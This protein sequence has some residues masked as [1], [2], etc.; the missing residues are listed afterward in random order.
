[1]TEAKW[2][3]SPKRFEAGVPNMAQAVGFAAAINYLNEVGM[4]NVAKHEQDLTSY[5]L[6]KFLQLDKVEVI[7]PKNNI[8]RGS[9]I[10]FTIDGIHPHDVGQVLDQYGVAVRTGHHCAWPL[11]RKLGLV[12]TT[13]ASF[14]VYNDEADIDT[15]IESILEAQKYFKV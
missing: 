4:G 6:E 12:G 14:Y 5:A 15:L 13:R 11:M 2:A 8:D 7:G 3:A 10:S 9:V 1:M